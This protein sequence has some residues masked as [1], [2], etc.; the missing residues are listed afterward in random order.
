MI[1]EKGKKK[2]EFQGEN[3]YWFVRKDTDGSPKL[4]IISADKKLQLKYGLD[5]EM[6][7]SAAYIKDVLQKHYENNTK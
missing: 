4:H 1:N 5:K 6:T 2:L 7:I 3:Y